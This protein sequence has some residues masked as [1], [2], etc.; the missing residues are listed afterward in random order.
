MSKNEGFSSNQL[1]IIEV[2]KALYQ[3]EL[4]FSKGLKNQPYQG[5]LIEK[6]IIDHIKKKIN[7]EKLK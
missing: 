3:N 5:Y 1:H 7:Y 6:N 4:F 2:C